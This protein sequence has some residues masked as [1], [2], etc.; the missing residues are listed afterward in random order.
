MHGRRAE[1]M[2]I[3]D[4]PYLIWFSFKSIFLEL[5]KVLASFRE[6]R[7]WFYVFMA[8]FAIGVYEKNYSLVKIALPAALL[9]YFV[10]KRKEPDYGTALRDRAFLKNNDIEI[11]HHYR[12]YAKRC[13]FAKTVPVE[14]EEYKK[15]ELKKIKAR[16]RK[17]KGLP[18]APH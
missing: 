1:K 3:K 7:T 14:Y 12:M 8:V 6:S 10:M 13:R 17:N 16:K 9:M 18:S 4:I 2:R 5:L 11:M 15:E